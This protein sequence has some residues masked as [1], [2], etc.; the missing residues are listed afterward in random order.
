V[1]AT[2]KVQARGHG[3]GQGTV[4]CP[5]RAAPPCHSRAPCRASGW[6]CYAANLGSEILSRT[7]LK[8]FRCNLQR[9]RRVA[10][11]LA[12]TSYDPS[13]AQVDQLAFVDARMPLTDRQVNGT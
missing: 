9:A 7:E 8:L 1:V 12:R 3:R 10:M 6:A 5:A 11:G 2:T 13:Q 4:S